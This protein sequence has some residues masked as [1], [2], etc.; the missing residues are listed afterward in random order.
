MNTFTTSCIETYVHQLT[1]ADLHARHC[2]RHSEYLQRYL[3]PHEPLQ[4]TFFEAQRLSSIFRDADR[5][6]AKTLI[7]NTH[8]PWK[9]ILISDQIEN[10]LTHT[11]GDTIFISRSELLQ[12][13][14]AYVLKTLLHEKVHI[15]QR[16]RPIWMADL[17]RT[18]LEYEPID[19][20]TN[21]SFRKEFRFLMRSNPDL[22][23][24][25][26][27]FQGMFVP[28][29]LYTS[30]KPRDLYDASLNYFSLSGH[31]YEISESEV[32][33]RT[34]EIWQDIYQR[35]H[36]YEVSACMIANTLIKVHRREP[37][38]DI[39][40]KILDRLHQSISL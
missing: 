34:K 4:W 37:L 23:D 12:R 17:L 3:Q 40:K 24:R 1:E 10:G 14:D 21:D 30:T 13:D 36:P 26:Y 11:H 18:L 8:I 19:S 32:N 27:A 28:V 33:A 22:D 35:E 5:I 39:E 6:T 31:P 2:T 15:L 9:L 38:R 29:M 16:Q 25:L 7:S 20:A